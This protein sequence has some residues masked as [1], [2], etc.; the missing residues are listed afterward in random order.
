MV[1][2]IVKQEISRNVSE[3]WWLWVIQAIASILFGIVAIF[4]P[5]LTLATLVYLLAPF[6][7]AIG[8]V[9]T[10]LSLVTMEQRD[11]WWMSLIIGFLTLGAGIFLARNPLVSFAT[12]V[13][14]VGITFIAWGI[15]DIARAFMDRIFTPHR[16]LSFISGLA[17][18][19]AGIIVM[20][21]PV[22]GGVAFV[23]ILGVFSLIYGTLA[24]VM[25]IDHHRDYQELKKALDS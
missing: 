7:I 22:A 19:A 12:F 17:G 11:T 14:V 5:G 25:S 2:R 13:L 20:L 10:V 21:Q 4:W 3:Y 1:G 9:E 23:W 16:T 8:L 24:L 15:L 18:I 6:I